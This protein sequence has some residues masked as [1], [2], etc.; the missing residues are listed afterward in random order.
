MARKKILTEAKKRLVSNF[1]TT[2]LGVCIT[3]YCMIMMHKGSSWQDMSG[4]FGMAGM[5]F[6]SKDSLIGLSPKE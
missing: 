4:F 3:I 5:L 1:A 2:I 6:R